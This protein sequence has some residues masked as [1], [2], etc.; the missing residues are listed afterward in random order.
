MNNSRSIF[1]FIFILMLFG[2]SYP[3]KSQTDSDWLTDANKRIEEVRKAPLLV[4]VLDI[5]G[6]PVKDADIQVSMTHHA[7]EF[8]SAFKVAYINDPQQEAYKKKYSNFLILAPSKM[9]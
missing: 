8:G 6:R 9:L 4:K 3:G 7:F 1:Y 2:F 5:K